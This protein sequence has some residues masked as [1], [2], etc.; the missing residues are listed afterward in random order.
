MIRAFIAVEISE[1]VRQNLEVVQSSCQKVLGAEWSPK[2]P[3]KTIQ[4]TR[5][6]SLHLTIKFLG[7]IHEEQV[8][9]ILEILEYVGRCHDPFLLRLKGVGVFPHIRS[10][11]ILWIGITEGRSVLESL[12]GDVDLALAELGFSREGGPFRP[13]LT[14]ARI[15][16]N[17]RNVGLTFQETGLLEQPLDGGEMQVG[18]F[19][20]IQSLLS[21]SG[22]TY[23]RLGMASLQ[24]TG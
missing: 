16:K 5:T 12:A 4:W 20:L 9:H 11:R 18:S 17:H 6:S 1:L 14:L 10:P 22:S 24:I 8:P 13:H 2:D 19:S 7:N 3:V 23:H 21:P 15:K